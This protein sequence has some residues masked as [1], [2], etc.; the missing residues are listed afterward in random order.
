[1]TDSGTSTVGYIM[2]QRSTPMMATFNK[3][4]NII[5]IGLALGVEQAITERISINAG[6]EYLFTAIDFSYT[7]ANGAPAGVSAPVQDQ[8]KP[9]VGLSYRF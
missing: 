9:Y 4:N 2:N 5:E 1:M 8:Y 3:N 6:L 7:L